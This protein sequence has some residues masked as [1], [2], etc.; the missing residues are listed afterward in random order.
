MCYEV[1][2][3]QIG[4]R[5]LRNRTQAATEALP[6]RTQRQG[7]IPRNASALLLAN[8]AIQCVVCGT[9]SRPI[10]PEPWFPA[11]AGR[12]RLFPGLPSSQGRR[13][14]HR[15]PGASPRFANLEPRRERCAHPRDGR[16]DTPGFRRQQGQTSLFP[17]SCAQQGRGSPALQ[18][19]DLRSLGVRPQPAHERGAVSRS[20]DVEQ[21][22]SARKRKSPAG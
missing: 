20:V 16:R 22:P 7:S 13:R 18:C 8:L 14:R 11:T 15:T 12:M 3:T 4:V 17:A 6:A 10:R 5:D 9:K 2:H 1:A 21:A 19:A